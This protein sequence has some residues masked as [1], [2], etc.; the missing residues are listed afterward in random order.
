M[1][2]G[3]RLAARPIPPSRPAPPPAWKVAGALGILYV[4]WG[5][6]YLAVRVAV[7]FWPPFLLVGVRF[8]CAGLLMLAWALWRRAPWPRGRQ[9][10]NVGLV[11]LLMVTGANGAVAWGVFFVDSGLAAVLIASVPLWLI[12]LEALRP[13][14]DRPHWTAGVGLV[15]GLAGVAL[16]FQPDLGGAARGEALWGQLV[17]LGGALV[18]AR[19]EERRVGKAC[20][21]RWSLYH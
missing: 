8:L 6:V 20:R 16:L 17:L 2:Q 5:S 15:L 13:R 4:V 18:A 1:P 19:S 11:G 9:W 14:G 10:A 21:S 3:R 7:H 12:A